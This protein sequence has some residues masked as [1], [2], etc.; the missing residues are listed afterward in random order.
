MVSIPGLGF[1]NK[2][3]NTSDVLMGAVLGFGGTLLIKG[4]GNKVLAGKAPDWLLKGSPLVGGIAAGGL[5]YMMEQK[6]SRQKANAHLF[7]ALMAGASVQA[8]DVLKTTFPEG[9]GDVVSLRF[10]GQPYGR[11]G[12]VLVDE[13]TPAVGPGG[14]AYNG[15]IVDEASRSMGNLNQLAAYSMSGD[16]EHS[17]IEELMDLD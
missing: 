4:L 10:A 6:K 11:L 2:S 5:L 15:L 17:G 9:L 3:V 13:R 7:G 8:W 12:S 16:D 1:V 14:A